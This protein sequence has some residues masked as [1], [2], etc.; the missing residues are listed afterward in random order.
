MRTRDAKKLAKRQAKAANLAA[1]PSCQGPCCIHDSPTQAT[2]S[3]NGS[4]PLLSGLLLGCFMNAA[5]LQS[6]REA[7]TTGRSLAGRVPRLRCPSLP[8]GM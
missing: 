8:R 5:L 1:K 4:R 7:H 2:A 3:G 6:P